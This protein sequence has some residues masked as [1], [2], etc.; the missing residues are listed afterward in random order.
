M[1]DDEHQ[2]TI[3]MCPDSMDFIN[4][5]ADSL[6]IEDVLDGEEYD[7]AVV[8]EKQGTLRAIQCHTSVCPDCGGDGYY[9]QIGEIICEECGVVISGDEQAMLSIEY[10]A[11]ESDDSVGS[12]RGL[13]K[14]PGTRTSRGTHEPSISDE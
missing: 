8:I 10:D 9:N 7:D 2:P 3:V 14:M 4:Q 12:S 13:E 11:D 5:R 6:L 1:N